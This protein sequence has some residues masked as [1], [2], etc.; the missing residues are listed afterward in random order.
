MLSKKNPFTSITHSGPN[1]SHGQPNSKSME[2]G[3]IILYTED[4]VN[5][6]AMSRNI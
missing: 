4:T 2:Q 3:S 1:M 5:H 6:I